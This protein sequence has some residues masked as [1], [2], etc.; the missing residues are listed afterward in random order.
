MNIIG[1]PT[2]TLIEERAGYEFDV[3][4]VFRAAAR[5]GTALEINANPARLDLNADLARKAREMGC[6]FSIDTDAHYVEDMDN[7][8]FGVATARKAGITKER[9]LN[10]RPLQDVLRSFERSVP[11]RAT[12]FARLLERFTNRPLQAQA[13]EQLCRGVQSL[14][15]DTRLQNSRDNR[16]PHNRT[17]HV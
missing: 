16:C 3:D 13:L 4:A 15:G 2:G 11:Q 8:L 6:I 1:H 12:K 17:C 9:V 14:V 5:T 10:A 7:M